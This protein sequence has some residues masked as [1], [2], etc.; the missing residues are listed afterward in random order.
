MRGASEIGSSRTRRR[1]V[2]SRLRRGLAGGPKPASHVVPVD[3]LPGGGEVVGFPVLVLQVVRAFWA[4]IAKQ[5]T[6]VP[7]R[8]SPWWSCTCCT[9]IREPT[10]SHD[11]SAQP[12]PWM[13]LAASVICWRNTENPPKVSSSRSANSP[14]GSPPP[15]G[16][17]LVQNTECRTW[18][19][20]LNARFCSSIEIVVKSPFS[21]NS[22]SR[23]SAALAPLT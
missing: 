15:A 16:D 21:R 4:S 22:W 14:V 18:P 5:G 12:D 6:F 20:T 13:V 8:G 3:D 1:L 23:S 19:E 9:T 2:L 10:G 17:R 7:G 11:A